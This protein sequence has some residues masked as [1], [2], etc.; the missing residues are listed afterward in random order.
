MK[1]LFLAPTIVLF[2]LFTA[3]PLGEVVWLSLHKTN[4]IT[5]RFVGLD[6]YLLSF[7]DHYFISSVLN[8]LLYIAILVPSMLVISLFF[9]LLVNSM[10]RRWQDASRLF[11][12]LPTLSA[13]VIIATLWKWVFHFD[14]LANWIIGLADLDPVNWFGARGSAISVVSFIV[15][16]ASFGGNVIF[17]LSAI[18][19][20]SK[21]HIEAAS[22]DGATWLQIQTRVIIPIIKPSLVMVGLLTSL[23]AMMIYETIFMLAAYEYSATITYNI[24]MQGFQFGKYGLASAQAILLMGISLV[25][26]AVKRRVER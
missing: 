5:S 19:G 15:V 17:L 4:F 9:A 11:L 8:S 1:Y 13:G 3:W 26:Y 6:N 25:L 12:Y 21:D 24:Y 22:M 7:S 10:P 23:A 18:Q 20:I 16:Y 2:G 14:G